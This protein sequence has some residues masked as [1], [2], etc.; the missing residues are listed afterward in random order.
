MELP[1]YS[2]RAVGVR[3]WRLANTTW[4]KMGGWLWSL[5][6]TDCWR[7]NV[8]WKEAECQLGHRI[9]DERCM[10]GIWAF[11]NVETMEE[12]FGSRLITAPTTQFA[13]SPRGARC[14]YITGVIVADG[15]IVIHDKGFRAQYAKVAAIFNDP[16]STPKQEI[17]ESYGCSV[18]APSEYDVFCTAHGLRRLDLEG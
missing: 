6:M 3:T 5:A 8:E 4:A 15:D 17:A 7:K 10:C 11:F 16:F 12:E 2:G 9:P 1:D 18:I 14:E 13:T